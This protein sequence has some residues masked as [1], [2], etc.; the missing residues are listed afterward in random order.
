M[1]HVLD[2]SQP[3]NWPNGLRGTLDEL[4]PV[5]RSWNLG[6][7]DRSASVFDAA[8]RA[9]GD[10]LLPYALRGYHFT[11]LTGQEAVHI[12][13]QGLEVLSIGLLNRRIA[14][15]VAQGT[16]T[17]E[18]AQRLLAHNQVCDS[19]R[20]GKA[21]F[22]FYPAHIVSESGVRSLLG[23]WGGEALYNFNAEDVELG[24]IL[25][26]LGRPALVEADV[27]VAFLSNTMGLSLAVSRLD[28][29]NHGIISSDYPGKFEDYSTKTLE[30][31]SVCRVVLHP[32]MEFLELTQCHQWR[33][34]LT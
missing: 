11:R 16:L 9:L 10:A 19:S 21:W 2:L 14:A 24:P 33:E 29:I 4:R 15:Q 32:D 27:P 18:Q 13:A 26:S 30:A 31:S 6:L 25:K 7:P 22:C 23:H 1:M 28:L 3:V 5:F 8:V 20:A 34:A 12:R 17:N